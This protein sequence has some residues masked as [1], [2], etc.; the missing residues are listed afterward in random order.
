MGSGA[1][2]SC[3]VAV[4]ALA[5]G[6]ASFASDCGAG[7]GAVSGTESGD[8][9]RGTDADD[10]ICAGGGNDVARGASG[11][12]QIDGGD[13][14]DKLFGGAGRDRVAGGR[15][16]DLIEV[17]DR[18]GK[19]SRAAAAEDVVV[20]GPSADT[21]EALEGAPDVLRCGPGTDTAYADPE[22]E[23][24]GCEVLQDAA[25]AGSS[26]K[27]FGYSEGA[28]HT[29]F[30]GQGFVSASVT[31][32]DGK[33]V[34][35]G[36]DGRDFLLARYNADGTLDQTFG[37][38]GRVRTDF[39][40][41]DDGALGIVQA[42]DGSLVVAGYAGQSVDCLPTADPPP[43]IVVTGVGIARYSADGE[44]DGSF[45]QGGT[46]FETFRTDYQC[47]KTYTIFAS[48]LALDP[49]GRILVGG[50]GHFVD[51]AR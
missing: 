45:G 14:N 51:R 20:G 7:T 40:Y 18:S 12:D 6:G 10:V 39:H 8:D 46:V 25:G 44:L 50:G 22:D 11:D 31:Q 24:R 49:S 26:D 13:G 2:A 43:S 4:C 36:G 21:I 47:D 48:D 23:L 1:C 5:A 15:G 27:T 28:K 19:R 35:A 29:D 34:T 32:P 3:V 16:R 37:V 30:G 41:Q 9:L 42:P 38:N 33:V 17:A